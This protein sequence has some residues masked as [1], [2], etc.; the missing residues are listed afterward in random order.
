MAHWLAAAAAAGAGLGLGWAVLVLAGLALVVRPRR[1]TVPVVL[2]LVLTAVLF[3]R[4]V[5][6]LTA[7]PNGPMAG[8]VTV[9]DDPV[10]FGGR[11]VRAG[12]RWG[13]ARVSLVAYG[14]AANALRDHL[15]GDQV[16]ISGVFEDEL[17]N[18]WARWRHEVG[19]IA[20]SD[21]HAHRPGSPINRFTNQVRRWLTRGA[22]SLP[23]EDR[24][25]FL[26]MVIGDD[27]DQSAVIADDFRS[28]GLG[29][30]LVVSGQNVAFLLAVLEPVLR[31][32]RP[33]LRLV[34]VA[35]ALLCFSMLT[36]F[37]PSVLRAVGMAGVS[38]GAATVGLPID[39]R[40]AL[41][42]AVAVALMVDPFLIQAVAFQLSVAATAGIVWLAGPLAARV[43]GPAGFRVAVATTV[44]AQAAVAP[45]LQF[46]FGTVPLF[47]LPANLLAGPVSGIIMMWGCTGGLIAGIAGGVVADVA[48]WPTRLL[49]GWVRW[50]ASQGPRWPPF[51]LGDLGVVLVGVGLLG[52]VSRV[53]SVRCW[54]A[55]MI[56]VAVMASLFSG[57]RVGP[58]VHQLSSSMV[59]ADGD[60]VTVIVEP[61]AGERAVFEE[62]RLSGVTAVSL[63]VVR[64]GGR[65]AAAT[66]IALRQ[67]FGPVPVFAP[68]LHQV[69]AARSLA[70][71]QQLI[72]AYGS[73]VVA[74]ERA[75]P[76]LRWEPDDRGETVAAPDSG[77]M[78]IVDDR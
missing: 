46:R 11:G 61:G 19:T 35:G 42:L 74:S 54:G 1:A 44:A 70:P 67:R 4:A 37:E 63:V 51:L 49:V 20:V 53:R 16:Q 3:E 15:S 77:A 2:V 58:G 60:S 59:V 68:P 9:T 66:V 29:H 12:A 47:S 24:A 18:D 10:E 8:W 76:R 40:K 55:A 78:V 62:L 52:V 38:V 25:T 72:L 65:K 73:V 14:R 6:G 69:P 27:R 13:Q 31:R 30:L 75:S 48:H 22:E 64:S 43:R 45:L 50:V 7:P 17:G 5:D 32:A 56:S 34:A 71:G 36:R 21:V 26:G 57:A 33:A 28:A 39:S 23:R 41:S